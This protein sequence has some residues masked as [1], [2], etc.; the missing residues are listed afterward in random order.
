[1]LEH[2][3]MTIKAMRKLQMVLQVRI[4]LMHKVLVMKVD[5]LLNGPKM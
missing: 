5:L 4:H 1:M 2:Q 3:K